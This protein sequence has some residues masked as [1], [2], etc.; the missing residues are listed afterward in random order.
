MSSRLSRLKKTAKSFR[1]F[2]Q[3]AL[4]IAAALLVYQCIPTS[5]QFDRHFEIGRPWQYDL[6]TAPLDIPIYKT[7]AEL[8]HER[9]SMEQYLVPYF[10]LDFKVSQ[11]ELKQFEKQKLE[12]PDAGA[13]KQYL[14]ERLKEVY[15]QG[16]ISSTS[17]KELKDAGITHISIIDSNRVAHEVRLSDLYTQVTAYAFIIENR[18]GFD[19]L[20]MRECNINRFIKENL[21]ADKEKTE[22]A[23]EALFA[24]I[25]PTFGAVQTGERIVDRGEIVNY[26]T[27][28][29][30]NSLRIVSEKSQMPQRN[31][32]IV[33]LGKMILIIGLLAL[34]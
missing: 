16:I 14:S 22:Q 13:Y 28:K 6:L 24:K 31:H 3:V 33:I 17:L 11:D 25:S 29:I 30:L 18:T 2:I 27:Y 5:E 7:D 1:I 10:T 12:I 15:N 20:S 23:R 34:L 8:R 32:Y 21:I 9:D 4:F 26:N 19:E